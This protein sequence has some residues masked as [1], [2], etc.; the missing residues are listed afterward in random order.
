M[1][2]ESVEQEGP[3]VRPGG[4]SVGDLPAAVPRSLIEEAADALG[5]GGPAPDGD[6]PPHLTA[7]LTMALCLFPDEPAEDVG[8]R[9]VAELFRL[10]GGHGP[11]RGPLTEAGIDRA[12]RRLGRDVLRATFYRVAQPVAFPGTWLGGR[13]LMAFEGFGLEVPDSAENAAE[14]GT[15]GAG[16]ALA[17]APGARVVAVVDCGSGTV[18]DAE[19]GP[20]GRDEGAMAASLLATACSEWA[21]LGDPSRYSFAA[22][23]AA[24]L[25]GAAVCWR[26]PPRIP[27]PVLEVL[28]EGSYLSLLVRPGLPA[29]ER[30]EVLLEARSGAKPDPY[31]AH[32][33]RVVEDGDAG[34]LVTTFRD[35]EELTAAEV[36]D[37]HRR[38]WG[39][40]AGA[41]RTGAALRGP[42][43]VRATDPDLVH[44]EIWAHLLVEYAAG[45]PAPA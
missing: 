42:G 19:V 5:L 36:A 35:P 15:D 3:V 29:H 31:V 23:G 25:T 32:P 45:S 44:Q 27:L 38:W 1:A 7:Y 11:L 14:F 21:L 17:T 34:R 12:R 18:V 8:R 24:A 26:V 4:V 33:V 13:R 22:F 40:S 20:R 43:G 39:R 2:S 16:Q 37:A 28:P 41:G 30:A 10:D 9:V 6:L